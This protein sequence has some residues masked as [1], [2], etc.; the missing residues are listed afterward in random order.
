MYAQDQF[1]ASA[2]E[3]GDIA[4]EI[5]RKWWQL[6]TVSSVSYL[7]CTILFRIERRGQRART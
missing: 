1:G 6:A 7:T 5:Q 2:A 4:A 3:N